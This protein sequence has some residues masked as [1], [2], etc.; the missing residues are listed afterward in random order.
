MIESI[1]RFLNCKDYLR[2]NIDKFRNAFI[3]FYGEEATERID[4]VLSTSL[5]IAY[6]PPN[7]IESYLNKIEAAK[8]KELLENY[9]P[10]DCSFSK[11]DLISN[12]S[13]EY[14]STMPLKEYADFYEIISL[15]SEERTKHYTEQAY[16]ALKNVLP[17]LTYE[18]YMEMYNTGKISQKYSVI[19][20]WIKSF[21]ESTIAP[22]AER[23]DLEEK[24]IRAKSL[25]NLIDKDITLDNFSYYM[26]NPRIQELNNL[27]K[28]FPKIMEEYQT[29]MKKYEELYSE[30]KK[31]KAEEE[32]IDNKYYKELLASNLDL[33]PESYLEKVQEYLSSSHDSSVLDY[34][35]RYLFGQTIKSTGYIE[36]FGK[37]SE[38]IL[39]KSKDSWRASDI[40][41]NRIKYFKIH[42]ID[43]GNDYNAYINSEE[44]KKIWPSEEI[45]ERFIKSKNEILNRRN[46]EFYSN[47]ESHKQVRSEIE[48][49]GFLDKEDSFTAAAYTVNGTA[50]NPNI[51]KKDNG[52][53]LFS[54][55]L[56][57]C[58]NDNGQIDHDIVHE[59][60]H[61]YELYLKYADGQNYSI[62]C[63]W[64][65]SDER[66]NQESTK[67]V[68]TLNERK[69]KRS[70]ELFN[71]IINE[72]IAQEIVEGM[73][74]DGVYV[75]DRP[76]NAKER[77]VT[78]YDKTK[79][80]VLEFF[81]RYRKI[82]FESR[83]NGNI[84]I[85]FDEVGK[86]NF[87]RLNDLFAIFNDNF[88]EFKYYSLLDSIDK[89]E[90]TPQTRLFFD[91]IKQRDEILAK[92]EQHRMLRDQEK[93]DETKKKA[94]I[95][96]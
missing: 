59:L 12:S 83:K 18:E 84:Q 58:Q 24:F 69:E 47:L 78:G 1:E 15:S 73:H 45:A 70:Y 89:K 72:M 3:K 93:E 27:A 31:V 29:F 38:E 34:K 25:L 79:I 8:T 26:D 68:D 32:R 5:L 67:E 56:V 64:D 9:I 16:R 42:G 95:E 23:K 62:C 7:A 35:L 96:G 90:N 82:I 76:D 66:M 49:I 36:M 65:I 44:A 53:E 77:Y 91:L 13:F 51:V 60:N 86:E 94:K 20:K 14:S 40:L 61:L 2:E 50:L 11:S 92:M 74:K 75:F 21:L 48:S 22:D 55:V 17:E 10:A 39:R 71:E 41:S 46:I 80:L 85:I 28:I 37:D 88:S 30:V 6:M 33:V 4:E 63:G 57:N 43:L 19:T 52:Y 81:S 54:L 87:D